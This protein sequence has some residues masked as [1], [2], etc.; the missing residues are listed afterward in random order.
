MRRKRE[1][2]PDW[3]PRSHER[4]F[5]PVQHTARVFHHTV[6]GKCGQ[7]HTRHTLENG[8]FSHNHSIVLCKRDIH[9]RPG[10]QCI[11]RSVQGPGEVARSHAT[12][13]MR[14][15]HVAGILVGLAGWDESAAVAEV[16][17]VAFMADVADKVGPGY[18][19]G[20]ADEPRVCD[21]AEGFAYVRGVGDVT[22]SGEEDCT[23]A[24]SV[25]CVAEACVG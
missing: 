8:A 5:A 18:A 9:G 10:F 15:G 13:D 20:G 2:Y 11:C 22:M 1:T 14:L 3:Y 17:F 19:V 21:W 12:D 16:S 4:D 24:A 25:G 6:N 7:P 23:N